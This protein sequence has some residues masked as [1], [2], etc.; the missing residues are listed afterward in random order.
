MES[1]EFEMNGQYE[2]EG[3]LP[4]GFKVRYAETDS[5]RTAFVQPPVSP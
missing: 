4:H 2:T 1:R 3:V 5:F